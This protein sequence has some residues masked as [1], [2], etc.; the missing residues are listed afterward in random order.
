[1]CIF[2]IDV[3]QGFF[4]LKQLKSSLFQRLNC[5]LRIFSDF[6]RRTVS[7]TPE[8]LSNPRVLAI[9]NELIIM[10]NRLPKISDNA[11]N[12]SLR[13]FARSFRRQRKKIA[14]K[15][16]NQRINSITFHTLRHW[17]ATME[18]HKKPDLLRVKQILGH[19]SI[20]STMLYT[21]LVDFKQNDFIVKVAINTDE[22]CE[23]VKVGFQYVTGDY[24]DGGKIFSKPK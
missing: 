6:E 5:K 1:M 17:K 18:Y 9:S 21:Q 24:N 2:I 22:A 23:L 3:F 11:F 16:Q 8:K 7:I 12:G 4:S 10:L 19:R 13:H 20:L 15:L 14:Y